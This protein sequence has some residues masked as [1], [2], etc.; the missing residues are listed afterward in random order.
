MQ[1]PEELSEHQEELDTL[2][3]ELSGLRN[4]FEQVAIGAVD[5]DLLGKSTLRST[6]AMKSLRYFSQSLKT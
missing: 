4:S 2:T 1:V 5:V 3:K 6:G